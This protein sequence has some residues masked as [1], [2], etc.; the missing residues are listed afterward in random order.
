MEV[1]LNNE[2]KAIKNI[3]LNEEKT[4][5]TTNL[6]FN[7][8]SLTGTQIGTGFCIAAIAGTFARIIAGIWLCIENI[9][10]FLLFFF[11]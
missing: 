9:I 4:L 10:D 8:I 6:V 7:N 5:D 2:I 11:T 3:N 1:R